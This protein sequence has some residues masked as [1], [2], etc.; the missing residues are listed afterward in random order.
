MEKFNASNIVNN[1]EEGKMSY[2]D[3]Y[4]NL[5]QEKQAV[6]LDAFN[7]EGLPEDAEKLLSI[8]EEDKDETVY[9]LLIQ[10]KEMPVSDPLFKDTVKSLAKKIV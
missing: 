7:M 2:V 8:A 10:I 5:G 3:L 9:K 4:K 6:L 1:Q